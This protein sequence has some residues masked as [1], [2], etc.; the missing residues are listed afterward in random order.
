MRH[1]AAKIH[2]ALAHAP[3]QLEHT[4]T[5]ESTNS[6]AAVLDAQGKYEEVERTHRQTL[7]LSEKVLGLEHPSTLSSMNNLALMLSRYTGR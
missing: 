1:A 5:F 4:N 6:F 2:D 7:Q 3:P